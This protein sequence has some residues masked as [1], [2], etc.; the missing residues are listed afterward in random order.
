MKKA[1]T[2]SRAGEY[3]RAIA[4]LRQAE[5]RING[6][7]EPRQL[8]VLHFNLGVNLLHLDLYQEAEPAVAK[9]ER[10]AADLHNE[11]DEVRTRW[12]K[13]RLCAGLGRREEAVDLLSGVREYFRSEEIAY[14][15]ALVS[16]ELATLHLEQGQTQLV[17]ELAD[18]MFWI[19]DSQQVHQEALAALTLFCQA[20]RLDEAEAEW[21]RRLVKYLYRAQH[22]PALRFGG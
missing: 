19:F 12:L 10:L 16:T 13:G 2:C 7:R 17:Q 9:A 6:Q 21:T 8:W 20:A 5:R 11:L 3:E 15:Y 14:D 4:V 18:E 22:D 1:T